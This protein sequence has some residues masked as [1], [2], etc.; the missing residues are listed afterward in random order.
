MKVQ[1]TDDICS[2]KYGVFHKGAAHRN[3]NIATPTL[4]CN[5]KRTYKTEN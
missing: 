2:N 4:K 5:I 3:I 1:S